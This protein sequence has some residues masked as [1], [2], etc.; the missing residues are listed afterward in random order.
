[1]LFRR[2]HCVDIFHVDPSHSRDR[3]DRRVRKQCLMNRVG[4]VQFG[5]HGANQENPYTV[6]RDRGG[7]AR[8]LRQDRLARVND[9]TK[10]RAKLAESWRHTT[11]A[12]V[13]QHKSHGLIWHVLRIWLVISIVMVEG[14]K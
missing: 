1:M 11:L 7:K 5:G 9:R 4:L 6:V 12:L 10:W 14:W 2:S 8:H 13:M 3:V